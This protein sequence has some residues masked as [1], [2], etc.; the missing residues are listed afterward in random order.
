MNDMVTLVVKRLLAGLRSNGKEINV[1]ETRI[2][3][4]NTA[5]KITLALKPNMVAPPKK[6]EDTSKAPAET[7][8][9]NPMHADKGTSDRSARVAQMV[10]KK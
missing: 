3:F 9:V 10:A 7:S 4:T 1:A 6:A 5:I 8:F 2:T